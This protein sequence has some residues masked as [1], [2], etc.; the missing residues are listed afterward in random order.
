MENAPIAFA[1]VSLAGLS[2]MLGATVVF[3][4]WLHKHASRKILAF[5]L[6]FASGIMIYISLV[7]IFPKA[8]AG[9]GAAGV[10]EKY[11]SA[12]TTVC[13]FAGIVAVLVRF[14][15][16]CLLQAL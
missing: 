13:F 16:P 12:L 6:A 9:F 14:C 11:S 4:P 8:T 10:A 3:I 7:D 1:V 5:S 2:T 15:V